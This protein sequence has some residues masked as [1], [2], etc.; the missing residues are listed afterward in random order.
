[1]G[2][3]A[4]SLLVQMDFPWLFSSLVGVLKKEIMEVFQNFHTQVV[5]E[6]SLNTAF[7]ALI[8]KKANAVEIKDFG[9]ISLVGGMYK[10]ILKELANRL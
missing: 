3:M 6:K 8:P 9:P 2:L 4:I 5:F 7:L 1:M 10:I